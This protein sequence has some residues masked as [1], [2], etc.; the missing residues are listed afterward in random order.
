MMAQHRQQGEPRRMLPEFCCDIADRNLFVRIERPLRQLPLR[1]LGADLIPPG[2]SHRLLDREIGLGAV[3]LQEDL[4][5]D[6][7]PIVGPERQRVIEVFDRGVHVALVRISEAHQRHSHL[8]ARISLDQGRCRR[9]RLRG[10]SHHETGLGLAS[11]RQ[12]E[13]RR[14]RERGL[15]IRQRGFQALQFVTEPPAL[16][17]DPGRAG[18]DRKCRCKLGGRLVVVPESPC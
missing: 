13:F 4:P 17:E 2:F 1:H 16:G 18:L 12:L 7:V 10:L 5:P 8:G 9:H 3:V 6:R 14:D 15:E 11:Q